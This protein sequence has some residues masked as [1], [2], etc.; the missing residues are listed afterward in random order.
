MDHVHSRVDRKF[1]LGSSRGLANDSDCRASAGMRGLCTRQED[2][3]PKPGAYLLVIDLQRA[4]ALTLPARPMVQLPPG[5]YL[6]CGS[7]RGPGGLR[8]RIGRH[9]RRGKSIRWHVDY[10]TG[11]A[12]LCGALLYADRSECAL[13][14]ALAHLPAPIAGFGSSDCRRCRAH[15]LRWPGHLDAFLRT[16]IP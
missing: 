11:E 10:L 12:R 13:V 2:I 4:V 16:A 9:L 6:Y 15:L 8:A 1:L 5:V 3:P 7:A 14:A